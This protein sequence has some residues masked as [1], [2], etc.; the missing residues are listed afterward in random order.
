MILAIL[1]AFWTHRPT[2]RSM[3]TYKSSVWTKTLLSHPYLHSLTCGSHE[4]ASPSTSR[5]PPP[6]SRCCRPQSPPARMSA[7]ARAHRVRPPSAI[8]DHQLWFVV[9][10]CSLH[11]DWS[12]RLGLH[13]GCL[14]GGI[15]MRRFHIPLPASARARAA[16]RAR[17]A[18][19]RQLPTA[20]GDEDE[21]QHLVGG[22]RK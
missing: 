13:I 18:R 16:R 9:G 2:V 1:Y 14:V 6:D 12:G 22:R 11:L 4:S 5:R 17:P 15:G 10:S 3:Y 8:R 21:A 19:R 7:R 20:T